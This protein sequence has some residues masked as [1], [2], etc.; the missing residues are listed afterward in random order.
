MK[1]S[2]YSLKSA[3]GILD[4]ESGIGIVWIPVFNDVKGVNSNFVQ[5]KSIFL[6]DI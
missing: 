4:F 2:N 1:F 6:T 5:N 3:L